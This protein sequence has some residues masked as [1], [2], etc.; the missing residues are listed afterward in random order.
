[1]AGVLIGRDE[2]EVARAAERRSLEAF[3]ADD[4]EDDWLEE[5]RDRWITGTPDEARAH[6]P[7]VRRRP[8]VERIMLQD[9]LPWDLDMI[10]VMGEVL[11]G[12][13]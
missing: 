6:G 10:D 11:V 12:Q 9:F 3:G 2:A 5:R 1:M 13:V 8:G 7:P 4:G